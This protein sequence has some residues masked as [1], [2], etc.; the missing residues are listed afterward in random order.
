MYGS[1]VTSAALTT[2]RGQCEVSTPNTRRGKQRR[3]DRWKVPQAPGEIIPYLGTQPRATLPGSA[4][5]SKAGGLLDRKRHG[6]WR[7]GPSIK[8]AGMQKKRGK[9]VL[10]GTF[11][12]EARKM[13]REWVP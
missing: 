10:A 13:P 9:E 3:W 7:Q 8:G 12:S 11:P 6:C 1:Q 4:D 2:S 5:K